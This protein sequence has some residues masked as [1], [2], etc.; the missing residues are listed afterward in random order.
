[1]RG[2]SLGLLVC[3]VLL[4]CSS[5]DRQFRDG[6]GGAG[7]VAGS[8]VGGTK[9]SAAGSS[10]VG[11]HS[12]GRTFAGD[13]G[14]AGTEEAGQSSDGGYGGTEEPAG[15]SSTGG[16][17][18]GRG[19]SANGGTSGGGTSGG[20][21]GGKAAGGAGGSTSGGSGGKGGGGTGGSTGGSTSGGTGA[22]GGTGDTT[23]PTIVSISPTNSATGVKSNAQIKITFSE[24]MN[25]SATT[26]ALSVGGFAA[27][28]LNTSWDTSGKVL[29]VTPKTAFAYATGSTPAG[30]PA[31]KYTVTVGT[32]ATDLAGNPLS[33]T[34]S[35]SFTT[36]RRITQ[37]IASGT[38]A[39]Y[40]DYGHAV[41]DGP[42]SCPGNDPLWV[43]IWTGPA[44]GGTYYV[45]V[46]FDTSVMGAANAITLESAT[47]SATQSAA[48]GAFYSAHQVVLKRVVYQAIDK[49]VLSAAVIDSFG[50]F[51]SSAVAQPTMN[52][53]ADLSADIT[54]GTRQE[55][56][57]LE[58]TGTAD[59]GTK[60]NFTCSG[61]Y[62]NVVYTTP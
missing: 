46:P 21:S 39:T 62:L 34:F 24:V 4:A 41:G 13:G 11:G 38:A 29:T 55:L 22:T 19:G 15:G 40:S 42:Q 45:F 26:Q 6:S 8:G 17:A 23:A 59:G 25:S 61:F 12:G 3:G 50:A 49:T 54:A 32:A 2:F 43:E 36:L 14:A 44:S 7:G 60:A 27:S 5:P 33:S 51:T 56:F 1:M 53:F 58:P 57:R 10:S 28:E 16:A 52:V 9:G 37:S 20:G 48:T 30:T 31:T 35:S 18:A 47:F